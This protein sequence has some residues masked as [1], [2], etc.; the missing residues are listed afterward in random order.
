M[1]EANSKATIAS[2]LWSH[3]RSLKPAF[4]TIALRSYHS[5]L[6]P[7]IMS[8]LSPE[9]VKLIKATVPILQQYGNEITTRF[10]QDMLAEIPDLNNGVSH[11][12]KLA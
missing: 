7:S 2:S 9:Q 8:S 6:E 5:L 12:G 1:S 11:N 4:L 3:S 10:Y